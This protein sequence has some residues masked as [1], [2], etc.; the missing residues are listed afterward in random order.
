MPLVYDDLRLGL[1]KFPHLMAQR[2]GV[3]PRQLSATA[4]AGH[5]LERDNIVTLS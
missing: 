3:F 2:Y 4:P 1:Q 5:R